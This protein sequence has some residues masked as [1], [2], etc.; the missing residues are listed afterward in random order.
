MQ[1]PKILVVDDEDGIRD[2]ISDALSIGG[3]EVET[4]PDGLQGL[5]AIRDHRFDLLILDVNMPKMDGFALLEKVRADGLTTP[6]IML[7]ARGQKV[8]INQ[9]L[10][11]G[12]DDYMTKPFG[13]EELSLRINAI[14][15]RTN[16]TAAEMTVIKFGPIEMNLDLYQV[17][18]NE[19]VIDFSPTEF[20]L[21]EKLISNNGKVLSKESLMSSVWGIDYESESTV[22]DTYISYLRRKLHRDGFEG[23]KTV[24]GV[25]FQI[26]NK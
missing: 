19:E 24:R 13:L 23:I 15:K 6:V 17:Q 2:L 18:F 1:K 7:S 3:F 8:D 22:V 4:S 11:L 14:L 21:L 26:T 20:R 25:G 5:K 12:A 16:K 10:R 9:G